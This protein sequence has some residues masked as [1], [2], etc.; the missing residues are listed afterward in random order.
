MEA[1]DRTRLPGASGGLMIMKEAAAGGFSGAR[2]ALKGKRVRRISLDKL[3][4]MARAGN[5]DI[6]IAGESLSQAEAN[7]RQTDAA[8]DPVLNSSWSFSETITYHRG[9][10]VTREFETRSETLEDTDDDDTDD[11]D[12]SSNACVVVDGQLVDTV[13]STNGNNGQCFD[14]N[15]WGTQFEIASAATRPSKIPHSWTS[16]LGIAYPFR[17]GGVINASYS[18][19]HRKKNSQTLSGFTDY[20]LSVGDPFGWGNRMDWTSSFSVSYEM[21]LPFAKDFGKFGSS[22]SLAMETGRITERRTRLQEEAIVNATLSTVEQ[23]FWDLVEAYEQLGANAKQREFLEKR[24]TRTK[25]RFKRGLATAYDLE[26][27]RAEL[28]NQKNREE[29]AWNAYLS[30]SNALLRMLDQDADAILLPD[31]FRQMLETRK[32]PDPVE[33]LQTALANNPDIHIGYEDLLSQKANVKYRE[34]QMMPDVDLVISYS[35]S[36]SDTAFGYGS[37]WDSATHVFTPD[38]DELYM[39]VRMTFPLWKGAEQAALTQARIVRKQADDRLRM[40]RNLVVQRVN[41]AVSG[42]FSNDS[43][44]RSAEKDLRLAQLALEKADVRH[45]H[46][47]ATEFEVLGKY[48]DLLQARLNAISAKTARRKAW[49]ELL[50][51]QG[52]MEAQR[53]AR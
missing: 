43:L 47:L 38:S 16:T 32:R 39:G 30:R 15:V 50:A 45:E 29:I 48:D 46:G 18:T 22:A 8:F 24:F 12:T 5:L 17:W 13:G 23:A 33:S 41:N 37:W 27:V 44:V 19:T 4:R 28:L 31:D 1:L 9:D 51:S 53:E 26:Q 49:T 40:T 14:N 52:M 20:Q 7:R 36:Q 34:N 11:T 35:A 6:R 2:A 10:Y 42:V 25:R 3:M 21:P